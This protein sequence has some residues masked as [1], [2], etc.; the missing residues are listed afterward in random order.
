MHVVCVKERDKSKKGSDSLWPM[1]LYDMMDNNKGQ[2]ETDRQTD[3]Q[4]ERGNDN[5]VCS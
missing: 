1:V 3:R 4:T 5:K 2:T